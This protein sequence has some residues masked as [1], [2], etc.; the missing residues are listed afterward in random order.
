MHESSSNYIPEIRF[1]C[2]TFIIVTVSL[3]TGLLMPNIEFVLG[4]VGSTIGVMICLIF[5][6][7]F[8]ITISTKNTNERLMAQ[9]ILFIGMWIMILGSYANLY[10]AEESTITKISIATEK[11][12]PQINTLQLNLMN[13]RPPVNPEALGI[14]VKEKGNK[15]IFIN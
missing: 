1:R 13:E 4:F 6:A 15:L 8:F 12:F 9:V 11:P 7:G 10:A 3:I 14:M 5:P 2:L